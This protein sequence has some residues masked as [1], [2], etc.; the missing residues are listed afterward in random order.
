MQFLHV[1]PVSFA[2]TRV[3]ETR[4]SSDELR[5]APCIGPVATTGPVG[6]PVGDPPVGSIDT[7]STACALSCAMI[8][9]GRCIVASAVGGNTPSG[10]GFWFGAISQSSIALSALMLASIA[11]TTTMRALRTTVRGPVGDAVGAR[12]GRHHV[13][14]LRDGRGRKRRFARTLRRKVHREQRD[15][16]DDAEPVPQVEA[17]PQ[18]APLGRRGLREKAEI[19]LDARPDARGRIDRAY[20]ERKRREPA[21]PRVENALQGGIAFHVALERAAF[22]RI[23]YAERVFGAAQVVVAR[24]VV[25][26]GRIHCSRQ[27]LSCIKLRRIQ[28]FI[29]PSGTASFCASSL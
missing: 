29:V 21:I 6:W 24:V 9:G 15:G 10:I 4:L 20:V 11:G 18:A 7:A 28:L 1:S 12:D 25:S 2:S 3:C 17:V 22:L 27:A 14:V 16:R 13:R 8:S 5:Q 23:E 26:G 19:A